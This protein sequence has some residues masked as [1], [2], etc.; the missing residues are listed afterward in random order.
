[1]NGRSEFGRSRILDRNAIGVVVRVI[2]ARPMW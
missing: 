1:M 2:V